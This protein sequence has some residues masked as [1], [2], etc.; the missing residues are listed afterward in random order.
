[1]NAVSPQT[2]Y[3]RPG[4]L[5]LNKMK[6]NRCKCIF[7]DPALIIEQ[8]HLVNICNI[9]LPPPL[10]PSYSNTHTA[11]ADERITVRFGDSVLL[12]ESVRCLSVPLYKNMDSL[13]SLFLKY[14]T[15]RGFSLH[16]LKWVR[17]RITQPQCHV[18]KINE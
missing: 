5:R 9:S 16:K 4:T 2:R 8:V 7:G 10:P 3:S 1:M 17:V 14:N 11:T 12:S 18:I 6:S 13:N 15:Q